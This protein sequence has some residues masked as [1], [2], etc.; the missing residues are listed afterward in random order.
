L[1]AVP[2]GVV[3]AI[4]SLRPCRA[5]LGIGAAMEEISRYKGTR[6]DA[7]VVDACIAV[8]SEDGFA[9]K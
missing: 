8:F 7:I 9:F 4:T 1:N 6:F 2:A 3:E 5:A